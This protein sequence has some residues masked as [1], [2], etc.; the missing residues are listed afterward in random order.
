[1]IHVHFRASGI[2][3]RLPR[4]GVI[5]WEPTEDVIHSPHPVIPAHF[6]E[7]LSADRPHRCL[8]N[9]VSARLGAVNEH[10]LDL[11]MV[12]PTEGRPH[13]RT[14]EAFRATRLGQVLGE[15][16]DPIRGDGFHVNAPT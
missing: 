6:L 13:P 16:A 15:V 9:C 3:N 7:S 10:V 12:E 11:Y 4:H 5:P 2:K 1:M 14:L 8:Q